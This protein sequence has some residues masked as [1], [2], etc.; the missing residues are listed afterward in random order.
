MTNG[1]FVNPFWFTGGGGVTNLVYDSFTDTIFTPI[2]SHTPDVDTV[3]SGWVVYQ[4][5]GAP[6]IALDRLVGSAGYF[7]CAI[8][9]GQADATVYADII[10]PGAGAMEGGMTGRVTDATNY[11][12]CDIVDSTL[13]DPV[14]QVGEYIAG[15]PTVR[16]TVTMTGLGPMQSQTHTM[17]MVFSGNS[18]TATVGAFSCNYSS[19]T[20]N[21]ATIHGAHA[22]N[23]QA[24][25]DDFYVDTP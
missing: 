13:T 23:A 16:D 20:G 10:F 22:S 12:Y 15:S 8:D 19:A 25:H 14:L 7:M 2:A 9:S 5:A 24:Q 3:G 4:S 1:A 11:W 6:I 18:I 17:T 21:A